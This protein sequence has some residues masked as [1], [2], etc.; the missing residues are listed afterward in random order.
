MDAGALRGSLIPT[1]SVDY[2]SHIADG[3]HNANATN[4]Q[5]QRLCTGGLP[6]SW[7]KRLHWLGSSYHLSPFH[8]IFNNNAN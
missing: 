3:F 8:S 2:S 5:N 6:G 4:I 1:M 7:I